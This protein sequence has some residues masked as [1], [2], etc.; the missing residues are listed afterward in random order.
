MLFFILK[1][2]LNV[3]WRIYIAI[4]CTIIYNVRYTE[5]ERELYGTHIDI[6]YAELSKFSKI[7]FLIIHAIFT[8]CFSLHTKFLISSFYL[9]CHKISHMLC[10]FFFKHTLPFLV[11]TLSF[12]EDFLMQNNRVRLKVHDGS[13]TY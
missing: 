4:Y 10:F 7:D 3:G 8:A 1:Y 6:F 9:S 13:K 11:S 12:N 2:C 5:F